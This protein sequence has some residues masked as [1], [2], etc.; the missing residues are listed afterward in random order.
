MLDKR[1]WSRLAQLHRR[2]PHLLEDL[3]RRQVA[4]Q[5]ALPR[6]TERARHATAR[7][8]RDA[9]GVA[10]RVA[11]QHRLERRSVDRPPQHLSCLAGVALDF[12][13]RVEQAR[14]QRVGDLFAHRSGQIGH[15]ARVGDQPAVVLVGQ[16]LAP[17]RRQPQV[18]NGRGA[19]ALVEVGE[20]PR[21]HGASRSVEN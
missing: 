15:L 19:S 7:L 12:T 20:V 13:H 14:E 8:R 6:R 16:L 18:R 4:G 11:H 3:R 21:R 1:P 2:S 17:K 5:P 10:L 9:R